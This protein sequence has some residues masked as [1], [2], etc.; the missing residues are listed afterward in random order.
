MFYVDQPIEITDAKRLMARI[1]SEW[2]ELRRVRRATSNWKVEL[3]RDT[4]RQLEKRGLIEIR[5]GKVRRSSGL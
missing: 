1:G 5:L 4:L 3:Y 2:R